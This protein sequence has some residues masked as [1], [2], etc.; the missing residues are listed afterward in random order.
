MPVLFDVCFETYGI[1][2][3]HVYKNIIADGMPDIR[4]N[5]VTYDV[6]IYEP[7]KYDKLKK[8][9]VLFGLSWPRGK[10]LVLNDF[11]KQDMIGE[12]ELHNLIH[13][14]SYLASNIDFSY[15]LLIEPKVVISSQ[16]A[17][18]MGVT[19]KRN[20]SIGHHNVIGDY[21]EIS[22]GVITAS[23]VKIGR[24]CII[25]TGTVI[26]NGVNIGD[27]VYIGL[28]SVVTKDIPSGVIAYGNPCR[29][30]RENDKWQI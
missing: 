9:V 20:S 3:F 18:G 15:G 27:N 30:I 8:D 19:I 28:G 4:L 23:N 2:N 21:T 13:P 24:A 16:S 14:T 5:K 11:Y 22:P 6:K 26:R 12:H 29:V 25:S 10:Y 7:G 1:K 17:I